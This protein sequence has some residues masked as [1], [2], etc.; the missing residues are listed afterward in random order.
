METGSEWKGWIVEG[1]SAR[2]L[3]GR[4]TGLPGRI[5]AIFIKASTI[6]T[7]NTTVKKHFGI[8]YESGNVK[9]AKMT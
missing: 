5:S 2:G 4:S 1:T 7:S 9:I 3:S 6:K 8:C